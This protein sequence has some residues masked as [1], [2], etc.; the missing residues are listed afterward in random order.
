MMF[1]ETKQYAGNL[2][3]AHS[4]DFGKEDTAS[5]SIIPTLKANYGTQD[6]INQSTK[7]RI[8]RRNQN[9]NKSDYSETN[10]IGG[11]NSFSI[12]DYEFSVPINFSA[13]N[14]GIAFTPTYSIPLNPIST[15]TQTTNYHNSIQVGLPVNSIDNENLS[16]SLY[17]EIEAFWRFDLK[18]K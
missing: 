16:N 18:K 14:W 1:Q 5:W 8:K 15:V 13:K 6:F 10:I 17:F 12:L 3:I 4:F 2:S 11:T 7:R 9:N